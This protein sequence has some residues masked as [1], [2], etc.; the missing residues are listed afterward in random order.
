MEISLIDI[1]NPIIYLGQVPRKVAS[2]LPVERVGLLKG[3]TKVIDRHFVL[4]SVFFVFNGAGFLEQDGQRIALQAPFMIWNWPGETKRY[5]PEPGWD[6]FFIGFQPGAEEVIERIFQREVFEPHYRPNLYLAGC[7][8]YANEILKLAQQP[9]ITGTADRIDHLVT[10][11]L[12]EAVY[13]HH[14]ETLDPV[15]RKL[16]RIAEYFHDNFTQDIN[17][18]H[19]AIKYG[20]SYPTFQRHWRRKYSYSPLQYLRN[21]RNTAAIDHLR[22]SNMSIG[23]IALELGFKNQFYFAKFF[24]DMNNVSPSE[25]RNCSAGKHPKNS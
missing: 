22:D 15:E 1:Q 9:S 24:R 18:E 5:W 4:P 14:E 7:V 10:M 21:L 8:R 20:M 23:D 17:I 13:P 16:V 3:K 25:Y 6:E 12:L 2:P 19:L 11:I